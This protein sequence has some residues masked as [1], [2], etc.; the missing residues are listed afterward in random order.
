[1]LAHKKSTPELYDLS[2]DIAET[3]NVVAD[4]PDVVKQLT[5]KITDI[6]A[7][8][9]TTAGT[10]QANDTGYWNDLKWMTEAEY[11]AAAVLGN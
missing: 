8:G 5:Q 10:S 9:R 6:V 2:T 3:T 7:R 4:H 1:M 11:K